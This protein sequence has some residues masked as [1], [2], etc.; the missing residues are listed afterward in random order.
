MTDSQ[1]EQL[2][3][4]VKKSVTKLDVSENGPHVGIIEYSDLATLRIRLSDFYETKALISAISRIQRSAGRNT[5]TGK[6]LRMA[7]MEA[8]KASSGGRP[9]SQKMLI[10]LTDSTSTGP[11][12][13]EEAVIPVISEGVQVYVVGIGRNVDRNEIQ[14][15]VGPH[16]DRIFYIRGTYD[17]D[18]LV[19]RFHGK[20]VNEA[21]AGMG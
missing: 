14:G 12:P 8:F 1:F 20:I 18:G 10:I 4:F 19:S 2:K 5:V 6:V 3:D 15:I 11:E 13:V 17:L 9:T 21:K 16:V 7:A